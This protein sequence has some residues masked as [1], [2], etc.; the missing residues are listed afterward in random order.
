MKT[1]FTRKAVLW[2]RNGE[3]ATIDLEIF[4]CQTDPDRVAA[5]HIADA[6]GL[7]VTIQTMT[8]TTAEPAEGL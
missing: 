6:T 8:Q 4:G 1:D 3:Q 2:L 7:K 5:A